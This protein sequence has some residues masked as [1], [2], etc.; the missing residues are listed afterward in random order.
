MAQQAK[1][2]VVVADG[3]KLGR[4]GFD[5]ICGSHDVTAVLTDKGGARGGH[6]PDGR[7]GSPGVT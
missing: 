7:R 2:T 6:P 5:R 3:D 1:R 4:V